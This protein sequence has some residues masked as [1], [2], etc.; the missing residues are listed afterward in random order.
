[1]QHPRTPPP[2]K[3]STGD[4]ALLASGK[5]VAFEPSP[6]RQPQKFDGIQTLAVKQLVVVLLRERVSIVPE[7]LSKIYNVLFS[8][9]HTMAAALQF[10]KR[11]DMGR[12]STHIH[13]PTTAILT[14]DHEQLVAGSLVHTAGQHKDG[15]WVINDNKCYDM[16]DK[17][18]TGTQQ[19]RAEI[20]VVQGKKLDVNSEPWLRDE[21]KESLMPAISAG[22]FS[23]GADLYGILK[24]CEQQLKGVVSD[25]AS[26]Q[27]TTD[28]NFQTIEDNFQLVL[29][30]NSIAANNIKVLYANIQ[31]LAEKF[32]DT[33][34]GLMAHQNKQFFGEM[35]E[36]R[37]A[38]EGGMSHVSGQVDKVSGQV[39]EVSGQVAEVGEMVESVQ[40]DASTLMK[41][42]AGLLDG[43]EYLGNTLSTHIRSARKIRKN[44]TIKDVELID[45][46]IKRCEAERNTLAEVKKQKEDGLRQQLQVDL[47]KLETEFKLKFDELDNRIKD[48]EDTKEN[49]ISRMEEEEVEHSQAVMSPVGFVKTGDHSVSVVCIRICVQFLTFLVLLVSRL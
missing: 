31:D 37:L 14:E 29:E 39:A 12:W 33:L 21:V 4:Q 45:L 11:T 8:E 32:P 47:Q 2:S 6:D 13:A 43:Q 34:R 17:P 26:N 46:K 1:M 36:L 28:D 41:V 25:M 18:W 23:P 5:R 20:V 16:S 38:F 44:N 9:K 48:Q 24:V 49:L 15:L 10:L 40:E 30:G 27:E 22:L 3:G 7:N 19:Q 42:G 35:E